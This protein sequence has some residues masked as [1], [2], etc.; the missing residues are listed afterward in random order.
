MINVS[1]VNRFCRDDIKLIENYYEAINDTENVWACHHRLEL[2]LDGE[3]A[4]S[5]TDLIRHGMYYHRPYFELIFLKIIDHK[6]LHAAHKALSNKAKERFFLAPNDVI[7]P[8]R[9][10]RSQYVLKYGMTCRELSSKYNIPL[11]T[12]CRYFKSGKLEELISKEYKKC[13]L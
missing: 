12:L 6:K 5:K 4:N 9:R 10:A 8:K 3:F 11:A 13:S 2:T 7:K 1:K